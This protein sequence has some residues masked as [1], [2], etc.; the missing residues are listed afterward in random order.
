MKPGSIR[1]SSWAPLGHIKPLSPGSASP[2]EPDLLPNPGDEQTTI[3]SQHLQAAFGSSSLAQQTPP[4]RSA[5]SSQQ[6]YERNFSPKA[7]GPFPKEESCQI[8]TLSPQQRNKVQIWPLE[9]FC[10]LPLLPLMSA[11]GGEEG[12]LSIPLPCWGR[13]SQGKG[14]F[15]SRE[16]LRC[17]NSPQMQQVEDTG[18]GLQLPVLPPRCLLGSGH[19]SAP[20]LLHRDGDSWAVSF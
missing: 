19:L 1:T 17:Q 10:F 16:N 7:D 4:N 12:A 3:F 6:S 11:G 5:L 15:C 20:D 9:A 2:R 8:P 13:V 18:V 14:W